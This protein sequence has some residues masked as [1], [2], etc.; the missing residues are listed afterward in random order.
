MRD[1]P[2]D[3]DTETPAIVLKLDAN[4]FH[5]GGLGVIRSLGRLGIP[6]YAVQVER[7]TPAGGSR[8]LRGGWLWRPGP[9]DAV[10]ILAGLTCIAERIGRQAV[11]IPT[12]DAGALFV[13]EHGPELR[14]HFLLPSP[15]PG[16]PRRLAD[17]YELY[18]LCRRLG[19]PCAATVM[20]GSPAEAAEFLD[21]AGFPVMVKLARPWCRDGRGG[22]PSTTLVRSPGELRQLFDS[23]NGTSLILQEY[24]PGDPGSDWFFHGYCDERSV[25]RP[26]FTGRKL[27]SYPAHAGVTSLGRAKPNPALS[28]MV[29]ELLTRLAYRGIMDLDLR[30]DARDGQ[31]KLLD[32]NPRIGASTSRSRRICT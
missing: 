27:R 18:R 17:K 4:V 20:A 13:A 29:T 26:A 3:V 23:A 16:L 10:R 1:L 21:T 2:S 22:P 19:M 8:Y 24:L 7:A 28:A 9:E 11:L 5:H 14:D 15:D 12:D 32:F 30:W 31:Y 6:V 25:C